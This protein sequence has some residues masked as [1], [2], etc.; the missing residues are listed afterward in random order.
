MTNWDQ[1]EL[2]AYILIFCAN[3]DFVESEEEKT[4]ILSNIGKDIYR[5]MHSEF[6]LDN[7]Y[8]RIQKIMSTFTRLDI[9][10]D[11][12]DVLVQKL[13][14]LMMSDGRLDPLEENMMRLLRRLI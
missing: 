11:E 4:F 3:A 5:K 6:Q 10:G 1:K 12:R 7:D 14:E 13:Q 2:E 8:E 9:Y